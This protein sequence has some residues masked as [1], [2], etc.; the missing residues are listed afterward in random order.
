MSKFLKRGL[1]AAAFA[2]G[3]FA[4]TMGS[5]LAEGK[6]GLGRP[7]L[8]EEVA[9]WDIDVRPDGQGLPKGAGT[10]EE[11]EEIFAAQCASCHGDFGEGIDR[12]PVLA[13]GFDSLASQNPVKTVGSYWPY[14]STVYDYVHRAMPFGN[15]QSLSNDEVYAVVAYILNLNDLVDYEFELSDENFTEI[16]LPNEANFI[17]DGRPD[18]PSVS[19]REPCMK[20]CKETVEITA[21]ARIIDV[22]PE[23]TA[24]K[25][26]A[27]E[28]R[29]A[30]EGSQVAGLDP[31]LVG[32]GEGL[33]VKRCKSC[34]KIE[35]GKHGA[36]PSL[37]G[38]MN[39]MAGTA[40]GFKRYSKSMKDLGE[41]WSPEALDAFLEKPR[42]YVPK[43]RMSF[44]GL[45]NTEDRQ[46]I[47]AYLRSLSAGQ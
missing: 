1:L 38:I 36:G 26:A 17:E 29:A 31:T 19:A 25:K 15:A 3:A 11:G 13:G 39:R 42:K 8:P 32:A 18:T 16:R 46:A 10:A 30:E 14:L 6:Y 20:N 5:S 2:G 4:L 43:T 22:T 47:I 41:H 37:H 34:H 35:P 12:W 7:A 9:A 40:E 33:F 44:A 24:A 23:E 27:E 45:K 28:T 21:R